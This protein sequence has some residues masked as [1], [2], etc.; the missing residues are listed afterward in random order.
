MEGTVR[1]DKFLWSVRLF[2]T[3]A[4]AAEACEKGHVTVQDTAC[5]PSRQVREGDVISVR[6][7]PVVYRY[8]VLA[9]TGNRLPAARVPEF[10][11]D[12]TPAAELEK[13]DMARMASFGLRDRGTGRPTKKDRR[14]LDDF[15]SGMD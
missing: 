14:E 11:A 5:K 4:L 8:R 1:M 3:R 6:K 15:F 13:L 9:L 10:I 12:E 7:M 2:K